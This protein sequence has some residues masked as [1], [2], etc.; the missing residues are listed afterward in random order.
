[1]PGCEEA[2]VKMK[3]SCA[4]LLGRAED[5]KEF[6]RH[7][8]AEG[9]TE[10][11]LSGGGQGHPVRVYHKIM[12]SGPR[13]SEWK[14]NGAPADATSRFWWAAAGSRNGRLQRARLASAVHF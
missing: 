7:G 9:W 10:I 8:A 13:V 11:T 2:G 1:M 3:R 12:R 4:Q 6:I 14:L 5:P